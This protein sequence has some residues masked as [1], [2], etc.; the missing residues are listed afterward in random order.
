MQHPQ[1]RHPEGVVPSSDAQ[2]L[3]AYLNL[4]AKVFR[5]GSVPSE[6][7]STGPVVAWMHVLEDE[8]GARPLWEVM[9]QLMC[10]PVPQVIS[11]HPSSACLKTCILLKLGTYGFLRPLWAQRSGHHH[12]H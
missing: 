12:Q 11:L 8:T 5:E 7:S 9:F 6:G 4:L 2:A 10:H 3:V 1:P